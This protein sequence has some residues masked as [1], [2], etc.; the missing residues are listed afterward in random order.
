MSSHRIECN[1]RSMNTILM[2]LHLFFK[3]LSRRRIQSHRNKCI[4]SISSTLM[5]I[6]PFF[7]DT[8]EATSLIPQE[9]VQSQNHVHNFDV[10]TSVPDGLRRRSGTAPQ[11]AEGSPRRRYR[12]YQGRQTP[13]N[14]VPDWPRVLGRQGSRGSPPRTRLFGKLECGSEWTLFAGGRLS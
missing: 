10:H 14:R 13:Y 4:R 12:L 2:S 1:H 6:Q 11:D 8:V 7:Q 5:S 3:T 9:W